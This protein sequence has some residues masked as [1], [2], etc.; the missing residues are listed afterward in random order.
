MKYH[1]IRT[2]QQFKVNIGPSWSWSYCSWIYNYLCNQY[3]SLLQLWVRRPRM[4]GLLDTTLCDAVCQW[5]ATGRWFPR[6]TSVSSTNK[7]DRHDITEILLKVALNSIITYLKPDFFINR[8]TFPYPIRHIQDL[9]LS[10]PGTCTSIN[11]DYLLQPMS[12]GIFKFL[13]PYQRSISLWVCACTDC[14]NRHIPRHKI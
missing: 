2:V 3:L 7:T 10:M 13:I 4:G 8:D 14:S 12:Y 9:S 5:L 6:G 1:T 11:K